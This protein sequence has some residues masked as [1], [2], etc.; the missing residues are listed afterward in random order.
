MSNYFKSIF[1][2]EKFEA[3]LFTEVLRMAYRSLTGHNY[4]PAGADE[5]KRVEAG[6]DCSDMPADD[7]ALEIQEG[8]VEE[9]NDETPAASGRGRGRKA[10]KES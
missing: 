1:I 2:T 3:S 9:V 10:R 5:E 7:L 4:T 8:R 6:D